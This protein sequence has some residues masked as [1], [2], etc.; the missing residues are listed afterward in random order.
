V[1][2]EIDYKGEATI[3]L[4]HERDQEFTRPMGELFKVSCENLRHAFGL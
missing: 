3:E 4:A 2:D 1:L